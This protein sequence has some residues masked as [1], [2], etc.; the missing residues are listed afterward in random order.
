VSGKGWL[1]SKPANP[2]RMR[3][4]YRDLYCFVSFH[5]DV[6]F[7]DYPDQHTDYVK[8]PNVRLCKATGCENPA[9]RHRHYCSDSCRL[10]SRVDRSGGPDACW[11]WQGH[12]NPQ[13]GYGHATSH[14]T[15][16]RWAWRLT[17]GDP[18]ELCVLHRCDVRTCANPKHLFLGTSGDNWEDAVIKGRQTAIL[19]GEANPKGKLT[20]TEVLAIRRSAAAVRD[21]VRQYGVTKKAIHDIRARRTWKH[22]PDDDPEAIYVVGVMDRPSAAA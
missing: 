15:A 12:V 13:N 22:L 3:G 7:C 10:W 21:L 17:Y 4:I 2:L 9:V 19:R 20:T 18:G 14:N 6:L 1:A 5:T 8:M 11:L 16:H